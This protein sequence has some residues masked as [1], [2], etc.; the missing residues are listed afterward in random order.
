MSYKRVSPTPVNE[1]G[2]GAT[3][4][5]GVLIGNGTS[6]VGASTVTQ[7]DILVGGATNTIGNISPGSTSGVPLISQGASANPVFG[8]ALVAGGGT[9][10]ATLTSHYVMVGAGTSNVTLVAP[11]A[12]A[13]IPLVSNGSSSDPSYTTAVVAGGGTGVTT[14]TT[15][16]APVCAGTTATGNLQVAST[17][18]ST[19]GYVLTSTGASSLPTFQAVTTPALTIT[20]V[21]HAASPYTVL[22]ADQFITADVTAGVISILL[23][24]APTTGRII[25]IKDKVGLAATSNITLTTVG[26][27][28]TIDGATSVAMNTAY[29]SMSVV[30]DGTSYYIY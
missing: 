6:A 10:L 3:T 18:L 2:T 24:N 25:Y 23:P 5:T 14:M 29:E 21:A 11:S 7:Y 17:G 28:V 19:S 27:I 26:G 12:T 16:Y 15:A 4:L 1:G 8:T 30:F 13:G 9:G 22:A 20:N